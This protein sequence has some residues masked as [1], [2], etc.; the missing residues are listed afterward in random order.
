MRL[1]GNG[2]SRQ[3][4]RAAGPSN[5]VQ[6][7]T[8]RLSASGFRPDISDAGTCALSSQVNPNARSSSA[9]SASRAKPP[10]EVFV[11]YTAIS[12]PADA[13][14]NSASEYSLTAA[15]RRSPASM[16]TSQIMV[17]IVRDM[18]AM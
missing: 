14:M 3:E 10:L 18:P 6:E 5:A 1:I 16:P 8:R 4:P 12:G 2:T 15:P 17:G 11:R 9:A 13:P 7:G